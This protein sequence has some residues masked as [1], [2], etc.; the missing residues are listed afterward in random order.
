[1]NRK[2]RRYWFP[3]KKYGWGWGFPITWEGWVVAAGF[4]ASLVGLAVVVSPGESPLRYLL[5]VLV[6]TAV[7]L[8]ICWAKGEPPKWRWGG[9]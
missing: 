3:A 1:M 4:V 2:D 8:A 7:F 9:D 6:A 5:L